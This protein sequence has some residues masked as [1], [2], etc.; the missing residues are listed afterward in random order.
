MRK[1]PLVVVEWLDHSARAGWVSL[2]DIAA[3]KATR[4]RS[5]GLLVRQDAEVTVVCSAEN[6]EDE[7][8]AEQTIRTADVVRIVRL[9]ETN[10]RV[11]LRR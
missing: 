11:R 3:A 5:F 4:C 8:G 9:E 7:L 6:E 1:F 2:E 10:R